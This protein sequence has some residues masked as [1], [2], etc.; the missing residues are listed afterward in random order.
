MRATEEKFMIAEDKRIKF[1]SKSGTKLVNLLKRKN[2]FEAN[3]KE[4]DCAPCNMSETKNNE[5]TKC[6]VDNV[7]YQAECK[8][9]KLEGKLRVYDGE[10]ARNL[11]IRSKEHISYLNRKNPNSWMFKHVNNEQG[12]QCNEANFTWKVLRKHVKP[13]QRQIHEAVNIDKKI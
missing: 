7:T 13:L 11:Y 8:T 12:G 4:V 9:C 6:R 5:L 10:T 2:P 3:C 1:V